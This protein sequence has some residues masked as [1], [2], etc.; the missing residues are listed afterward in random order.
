MRLQHTAL[1]GEQTMSDTKQ[2]SVVGLTGK[3]MDRPG[4]QLAPAICAPVFSR[5]VS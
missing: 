4:T 1:K 5:I 3:A 2:I